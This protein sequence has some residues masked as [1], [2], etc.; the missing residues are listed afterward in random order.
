LLVAEIAHLRQEISW[1]QEEIAIKDGRMSR[2]PPHHRPHYS[3]TERMT[4]LELC[5]AQGLSIQRTADKF[6]DSRGTIHSWR[7]RVT[8]EGE[9]ALLALDEPVNKYPDYV[10]HGIRRIKVLFPFLGKE[11]ISELL[12][13]AGLHVASSTIGRILKEAPKKLDEPVLDVPQEEATKKKEGPI[14]TAKYPNHVWHIDLTVVPILG[15]FAV[16]LLPKVLPQRWPF[17]WRVFVVVD[18]FSRKAMGFK[19]YK[20]K[21]SS[22]EIQEALDEI[23]RESDSKPK[24]I[25]SDRGTQFDCRPFHDWCYERK[26]KWRHGAVG[27]HGSIAVV[28]RYILTMK[29][30]LGSCACVPD[31]TGSHRKRAWTRVSLVQRIPDP[32]DLGRKNTERQDH[33]QNR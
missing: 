9:N 25:I 30:I 12:C 7:R 31:E 27:K 32:L 16:A 28:K 11:K 17:G 8:E 2:I 4:I 6:L 1:L 5:E 26:I 19:V 15:R 10:R 22:E 24:H 18:H 13:K 3:G 20:D 14:V 21:P 23:I 33:L 29:T